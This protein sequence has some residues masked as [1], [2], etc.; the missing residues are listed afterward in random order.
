MI[1][2]EQ[3]L[4]HYWK[5]SVKRELLHRCP[6]RGVQRSRPAIGRM[7]A[8]LRR[9]CLAT[10]AAA[11]LLAGCVE[12]PVGYSRDSDPRAAGR[13]ATKMTARAVAPR[14]AICAL[15]FESHPIGGTQLVAGVRDLLG[16]T[17][18][19]YGCSSRGQMSNHG[20]DLVSGNTGSVAVAVLAGSGISFESVHVSSASNFRSGLLGL[21]SRAD[22]VAILLFVHADAMRGDAGALLLRAIEDV[23]RTRDG[24]LPVIGSVADG[25]NKPGGRPL[26]Y[27]GHEIYSDG[28]VAVAIS[29]PIRA[30][31]GAAHSLGNLGSSRTVT[32]VEGDTI[33]RL[34]D[35]APSA[36]IR[37]ESSSRSIVVSPTH[38]GVGTGFHCAARRIVEISVDGMRLDHPVRVGTGVQMLVPRATRMESIDGDI[39]ALLPVLAD[40]P[41]LVLMFGGASRMLKTRYQSRVHEAMLDE[42]AEGV[43]VIGLYGSGQ[44]GPI[45]N[46]V[47][48]LENHFHQDSVVVI[49]LR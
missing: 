48:V 45:R 8:S 25:R 34:N 20:V 28:V 15:L 14:E 10:G 31:F 29:G 2:L 35:R 27:A 36:V 12:Q 19:I 16:H 38:V 1:M 46:A 47:G 24:G 6:D 44:F 26:L 4:L 22:P 13:A 30:F 23:G 39:D 43:P 11:C 40:E 32:D 33:V 37:S 3:G 17:V 21:V 7:R 18:P 49:G 41:R 5:R 42:V 9:L